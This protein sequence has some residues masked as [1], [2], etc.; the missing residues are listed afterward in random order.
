MKQGQGLLF[1]GRRAQGQPVSLVL[2]NGC[3]RVSTEEDTRVFSCTSLRVSSAVGGTSR[4]IYLP[5]GLSCEVKDSAFADALVPPRLHHRLLRGLEAHLGLAA[6]AAVLV[7]VIMAW[8][9]MRAVPWLANTTVDRL[10]GEAFASAGGA[11]ML[12]ID[13]LTRPTG[14][15][16]AQQAQVTE[17]FDRVR[18][19]AGLPD[20]TLH[21]R[22]GRR[23]GANAL[24]IPGDHMVIT[25]QLVRLAENDNELLGVMAHEFGHLDH[26]HSM[27][28]F[29]MS[30]GITVIMIVLLGDVSALFDQAGGLPVFLIHNGYARNF[31]READAYA[32]ALMREYGIEPW[33]LSAL[34]GR[35]DTSATEFELD[36]L[37]SHPA[38]GKRIRKM[39]CPP[40]ANLPQT[41]ILHLACAQHRAG[42]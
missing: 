1:D 31:E 36:Y 19:M 29:L 22:D 41:G 18:T 8:V 39:G 28:M 30:T 20:A 5:D 38:T 33:H 2:D 9:M 21:L 16:T 10:P 26:Q 23:I 15:S 40:A 17:L 13:Q 7:L 32:S 4:W 25:D 11:A 12:A 34:L 42:Q 37:S 14:L 6:I 27:R 35:L 24:A 3:L